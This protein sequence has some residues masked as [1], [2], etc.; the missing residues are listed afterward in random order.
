VRDVAL[1]AFL[2]ALDQRQPQRVAQLVE[3]QRLEDD[4]QVQAGEQ[5]QGDQQQHGR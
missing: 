1:G 4:R 5:Q 2:L 3:L